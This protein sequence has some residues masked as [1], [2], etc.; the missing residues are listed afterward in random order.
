MGIPKPSLFPLFFLCASVPL[1]QM[2]NGMSKFGWNPKQWAGLAPNGF[3]QVKPNHYLDMAKIVWRNRD[4]LPYAWR[5]LSQGVCDG[6]ALGTSGLHDYTMD[7][8]HLCMVRLEL[9][10]LNT[11]P[12][13]D[14]RGLEDADKLAK[15]SAAELRELGRLPFPLLRRRGER[16]CRSRSPSPRPNP[17]DARATTTRP[18]TTVRPRA[19]GAPAGGRDARG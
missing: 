11:M 6:C 18:A 19:G 9:L 1:W 10:R 15:M 12:A 13:L 8:V 14:V 16:G 3:G 7:G 4:Q 17:R 5:I 2:Q